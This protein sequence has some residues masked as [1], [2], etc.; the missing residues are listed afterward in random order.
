VFI[1]DGLHVPVIPLVEVV[2]N[3]PGVAPTQYGPNAE[4]RGVTLLLILIV[5]VALLA[6]NPAEGVNV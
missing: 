5:S 3:T 6:H 4:N 2:G 1:T